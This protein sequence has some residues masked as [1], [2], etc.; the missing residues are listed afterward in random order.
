MVRKRH[1]CLII[2]VSPSSI[3]PGKCIR[4]ETSM[5]R[6]RVELGYVRCAYANHACICHSGRQRGYG[7]EHLKI[8]HYLM[9][10]VIYLVIVLVVMLCSN[11]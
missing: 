6:P 9:S 10:Y 7:V 11:I 5:P 2:R 4:P 1:S 8:T 3:M